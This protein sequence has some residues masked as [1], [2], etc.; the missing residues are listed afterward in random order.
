M[1]QTDKIIILDMGGQYAH[2]LARRVRQIGVYSQIMPSDTSIQLLKDAK[3]IIISGGPSSV[4]EKN[5]PKCDPK[6]FTLKTPILGLCYG[7]QLMA[8]SLGGKVVPGKIKEYGIANLNIIKNENTKNK[9]IFFGNEK[10]E[11]VWMSHGDAVLQTPFGFEILASTNDCKVAAMGNK[12]LNYFGFQFHPEV[13]HTKNGMKM[14]SNFVLGICKAK[15]LWN[16]KNFIKQKIE[17]IKKIVGKKNVFL[18]VSGGVDSTVCFAL[19]NL[20]LGPKRVYGLH[21]DNGFMRKNESSKVKLAILKQGWNNF[22]VIDASNEFLD[23]VKNV[24]DPEKKRKIIGE[25]FIK[26]QQKEV[27]KL[28]LNPNEWM[29]GQ[30][31]I[32]PDTIETKGTK[33]SDLIKTHHNRV[34]L[35]QDLIEKG[36][37]IEP[38]KELYKDEV[39]SLGEKLKLPKHLILRHPFPGPGLAVRCLCLNKSEKINNE[40]EIDRK[41]N[42][43][44][45]KFGI[46]SKVLPIKSVGVQGDSR[47]YRHPVLIQGGGS[48]QIIEKMSTELTNKFKEINRV[49]LLLSMN[50]KICDIKPKE[51][52]YLTKDR[53]DLLRKADDVVAKCLDLHLYHKIWQFPVVLVPLSTQGGEAIILRPVESKEA[54]TANWAKLPEETLGKIAK[55]I[56]K[57]KGIDA[58]FLDVTNKPPGTI[59]WE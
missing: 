45:E 26:V 56:L 28:N 10:T 34:Q 16:M 33:H 39:R 42:L 30:G 25:T 59:E 21:I 8:Q 43:T 49:V 27:S 41:L 58:V 23:A 6:L 22:H 18:L 3:G 19:L 1:L 35:V 57:I 55:E 48:F 7:H 54:M 24:A 13:T 15:K 2:L 32:Y 47:T 31:T 5:S 11:E 38:I 46:L 36:M 50:G 51:K 4:Y 12:K 20:A 40:D 29:L 53:L 44:T 14:L 37:V 9:N 17:E 52:T